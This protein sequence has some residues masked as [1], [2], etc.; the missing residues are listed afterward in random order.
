MRISKEFHD[1]VRRC[2]PS[3]FNMISA[4]DD[5][6]EAQESYAVD[7]LPNPN[8]KEGGMYVCTSYVYSSYST[9]PSKET[10]NLCCRFNPTH[11][12]AS[13]FFNPISDFPM[14][15]SLYGL[16]VLSFNLSIDQSTS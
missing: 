15:C 14:F 6:E 4:A 1:G 16:S 8:G 13:S 3:E 10:V 12:T 7:Q 2:I 5:S 11:D 9:V